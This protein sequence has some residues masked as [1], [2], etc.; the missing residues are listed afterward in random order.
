MSPALL[1]VSR[2]NIEHKTAKKLGIGTNILIT[3]LKMNGN[4]VK[5]GICVP[6]SPPHL[7]CE[8]T[9]VRIRREEK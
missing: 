8:V 1:S 6:R 4:Q 7:H 2:L 3:V 5:I 9:N